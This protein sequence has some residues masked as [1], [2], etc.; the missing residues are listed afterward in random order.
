M[1]GGLGAIPVSPKALWRHTPLELSRVLL[2]HT[3]SSTQSPSAGQ[4]YER[5][6]PLH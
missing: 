2:A 1:R 6:G 5:P 4:L 3:P